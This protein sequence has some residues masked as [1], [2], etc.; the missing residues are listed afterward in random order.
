[1]GKIHLYLGP[2]VLLVGII[3]A[4]L[5]LSLADD[6]CYNV[7]YAVVIIVIAALFFASRYAKVWNDRCNRHIEKEDT[8]AG[9]DNAIFMMP[10]NNW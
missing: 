4:P 7:A 6:G 8:R 2:A 9:G 10:S 5:G 1:M 3:N